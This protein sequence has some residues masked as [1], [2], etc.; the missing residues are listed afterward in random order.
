MIL[1]HGWTVTWWENARRH[2]RFFD[3][4]VEARSFAAGRELLVDPHTITVAQFIDHIWL[5][6]RRLGDRTDRRSGKPLSLLTLAIYSTAIRAHVFPEIGQTRLR[7][8]TTADLR[9]VLQRARERRAAQGRDHKA[10]ETELHHL[11]SIIRSVTRHASRLD[12]CQ[13]S[14]PDR[15][16]A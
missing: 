4:E 10:I 12:Y 7:D 16:R 1:E 11:L 13:V 15:Q 9:R 14:P 3:D 2:R 5:P 8:L 6:L